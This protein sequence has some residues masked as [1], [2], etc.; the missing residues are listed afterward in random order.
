MEG[1]GDGYLSPYSNP[2]SSEHVLAL[3][4]GPD[5]A[6]APE[7]D[8]VPRD[9]NGWSQ[10]DHD[11]W[12]YQN[13]ASRPPP[14]TLEQNRKCIT[15]NGGG[16]P[17]DQY[18]VT[19]QSVGEPSIPLL[20]IGKGPSPRYS[21]PVPPRKGVHVD[22]APSLHT[23]PEVT[24]KGDTNSKPRVRGQEDPGN[25]EDW[26]TRGRPRRGCPQ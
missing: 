1:K 3:T 7:P 20:R 10:E 12:N 26:T 19:Q 23:I 11:N 4:A 25:P 5:Q 2:Q 15:G 14:P 16:Y 17:Q 21:A 24:P 6:S 13:G 22:N 9:Q 8:D 18:S